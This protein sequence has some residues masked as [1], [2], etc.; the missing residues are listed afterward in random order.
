M[1]VKH[2]MQ[3]LTAA[4][5]SLRQH[6]QGFIVWWTGE[7]F[8][9]LPQQLTEI[10]QRRA[11]R[12]IVDVDGK[13]ATFTLCGLQGVRKVGDLDFGPNVVVQPRA[14]DA[15]KKACVGYVDEVA[16]RLPVEQGLRRTL[17]LP[18]AAAE[19]LREVLAF[20]MDRH[21]PFKAEQVYYDFRIVTRDAVKRSL[22]V[23][24]TLVPRSEVDPLA[25]M[26]VGWGLEPTSLDIRDS[27]ASDEDVAEAAGLNLLPTERRHAPRGGM[28]W[29]NPILATVATALLVTA[30]ALPFVQKINAVTQL[31]TEV[32]QARQEAIMAEQ[33]RTE[34]EQLVVEVNALANK[35]KERPIVIQVV[36]ELTHLLPDSTWITRLEVGEMRV[37]IRGESSN[38]SDLATLIVNSAL[39]N[40][41]SF[42]SPVTRN[43]KT[44]QERFVISATV[45]RVD[46]SND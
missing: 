8:A 12:L 9:L 21:T 4:G 38:A 29:Q 18:L 39:F 1:E 44:D 41:A 25:E 22:R 7:L 42:D 35:R 37:K 16:V 14:V 28:S 23:E 31:E 2:I 24:L 30:I 19:N 45:A 40:D 11:R 46:V 20:E 36:D 27:A 6:V 32:K 5:V 26:L 3:G 10:M 13:R 15:I 33:V 17:T 43:P 34:L